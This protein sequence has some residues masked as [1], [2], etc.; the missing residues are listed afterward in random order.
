ML[1][2]RNRIFETNSSSVHSITFISD[3]EM[4]AFRTGEMLFDKW[5]GMITREDAKQDVGNKEYKHIYSN[6][7]LYELGYEYGGEA[8]ARTEDLPD[9]G[10]VNY[11]CYYGRD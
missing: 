8:F 7:D 5:S 3:A 6:D 2:I 4:D 9:G 11:I 1:Q 10:H